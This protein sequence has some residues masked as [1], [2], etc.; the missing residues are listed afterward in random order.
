MRVHL[1][2]VPRKHFWLSHL[3][4]RGAVIPGEGPP[5][6]VPDQPKW[7]ILC[8][9]SPHSRVSNLDVATGGLHRLRASLVGMFAG[10]LPEES[11]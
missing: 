5:P 4:G 6:W 10:G 9:R 11:Q 1:P 2:N 3:V 7:T 8:V